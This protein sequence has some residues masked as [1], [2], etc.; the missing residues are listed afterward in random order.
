MAEHRVKWAPGVRA[1][2]SEDG[3]NWESATAVDWSALGPCWGPVRDCIVVDSPDLWTHPIPGTCATCGK[4]DLCGCPG[5]GWGV[6]VHTMLPTGREGV[7]IISVGRLD[8]E[9]TWKG[10]RWI[11][12]GSGAEP[13]DPCPPCV[14]FL[15]GHPVWI[16]PWEDNA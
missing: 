5:E 15:S 11:D 4:V 10:D 16:D 3:Q 2:V 9:F 14:P 6:P 1:L 8:P 12:G 13:G 7:W